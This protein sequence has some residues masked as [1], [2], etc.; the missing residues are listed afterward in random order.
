MESC[1]QLSYGLFQSKVMF[2]SL[3]DSPATLMDGYFLSS[4]IVKGLYGW[5]TYMQ[6]ENSDKMVARARLILWILQENDLFIWVN[7]CF[8][9][10]TWVE[11]LG[12]IIKDGKVK[13]DNMKLDGIAKW[14]PPETVTQLQSF[15][16]FYNYYHQFI[17][18]YLDKCQPLNALL[19]KSKL[20][21]WTPTQHTAF[22][23][24]KVA[25]ILKPV[26]LMPDFLKPFEIEC[27]ASLFATGRVLLQ[28]D[29]NRDWHP[30]TY[31]SKSLTATE[32]N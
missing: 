18:H 12:F 24:L 11:F 23:N 6:K 9:F 8:F 28:K 7:K 10:V 20:W 13:M 5:L 3:W 32:Q 25:F 27:N 17:K 26:L 19:Q 22:K 14:P 15:L 30:V 4:T 16:G 2:F 29:T 21:D 1:L 31:H